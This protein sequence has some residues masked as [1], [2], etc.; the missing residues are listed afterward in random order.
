MAQ[1]KAVDGKPKINDESIKNLCNAL[2]A[3]C[4]LEVA[5]QVIDIDSAL[6][7]TWI[8]KAH[9]NPQSIYGKFLREAN[10]AMAECSLR[11]ILNIDKCAMGRDPEYERDTN[12]HIMF[13]AKGMPIIKRMGW[14]PNW[15]AS[16]W[17]LERRN[18]DTWAPKDTKAVGGESSA[19]E[20][21][22]VV[23]HIPSNGREV[24]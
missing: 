12:G 3:G 7:Y 16:R 22:Q 6:L 17:R 11:D 20:G 2:R 5:A 18:P 21:V 24:K 23:V 4:S 1:R 8:K 13:N 15:D 10:K 9:K 19:L 14:V